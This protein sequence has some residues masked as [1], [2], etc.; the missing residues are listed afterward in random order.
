MLH[1]CMDRA[2]G[3]ESESYADRPTRRRPRNVCGVR[4]AS[5]QNYR[6]IGLRHDGGDCRAGLSLAW[7]PQW[8]PLHV[9]FGDHAQSA[10][11]ADAGKRTA[12]TGTHAGVTGYPDGFRAFFLAVS[13]HDHVK[14]NPLSNPAPHAGSPR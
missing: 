14:A 12:R 3:D 11:S 13:Y 10:P 2:T 8:I 4:P 7:K 9:A 5:T 6:A 1:G